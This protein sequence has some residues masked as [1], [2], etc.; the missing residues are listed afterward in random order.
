MTKSHQ[1]KALQTTHCNRYYA[2]SNP[3]ERIFITVQS[4]VVIYGYNVSLIIV[5]A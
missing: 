5:E 2:T 3:C 4:E 1:Q